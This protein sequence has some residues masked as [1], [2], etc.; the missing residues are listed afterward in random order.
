MLLGL[1]LG[2]IQSAVGNEG[3]RARSSASTES[4]RSSGRVLGA[5][6]GCGKK[7]RPGRAA[8]SSVKLH[9]AAALEDG[10]IKAQVIK[11]APGSHVTLVCARP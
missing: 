4:A 7:A 10:H 9:Y 11:R 8:T 2:N 3:P 6:G 5:G 1:A